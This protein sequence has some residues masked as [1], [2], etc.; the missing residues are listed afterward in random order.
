MRTSIIG[1]CEREFKRFCTQ[2]YT[3]TSERHWS[4]PVGGKQIS[5]GELSQTL[6]SKG[7]SQHERDRAW[8]TIASNVRIKHG[9]WLVIA[10]GVAIPGIRNAVKTAAVYAPDCQDRTELESAALAGFVYAIHDIDLTRPNICGRLCNRAY[11]AARRCAIEL[12]RYQ[13]QLRSPT[14]ESH[15]PALEFGHPDLIL[16]KASRNG[17]ITKEQARLVLSIVIEHRPIE[18]EAAA[19]EL[20]TEEAEKQINAAK[21][22][23]L[24]WL[25]Q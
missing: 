15:P 2:S 4:I 8:A 23:L 16:A 5:T 12:S 10:T 20:T 6:L 18:P 13:R 17:I 7:T 9:P 14:F 3:R 24:E 19:A 11:V 25:T 21:K 22:Q 1:N